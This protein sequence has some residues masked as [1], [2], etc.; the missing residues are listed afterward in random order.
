MNL[1][2]DISPDELRR[3]QHAKA[4]GIDVDAKIREALRDLPDPA[5]SPP[6][7]EW[8]SPT[9]RLIQSWIDEGDEEEQ[10][11][12][13]K[14]LRAGLNANHSSNRRIFP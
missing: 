5:P 13:L 1:T 14:V 2:I 8:K 3:I 6:K 10:R 9:A 11:E 12:T 7:R 4:Q